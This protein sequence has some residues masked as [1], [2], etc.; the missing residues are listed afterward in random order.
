MSRTCE[1]SVGTTSFILLKHLCR[2]TDNQNFCLGI[3]PNDLY[4]ELRFA[5]L[6]NFRENYLEH[7]A[8]PSSVLYLA[9]STLEG[10]PLLS[11][12]HPSKAREC[13]TVN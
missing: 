10:L 4:E 12:Q 8:K 1:N 5:S 3:R 9:H 6:R 2:V 7:K 13:S 11:Q